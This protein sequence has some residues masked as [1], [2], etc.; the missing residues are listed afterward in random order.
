MVKLKVLSLIPGAGAAT[1]LFLAACQQSESPALSAPSDPEAPAAISS[2]SALQEFAG[3]GL[4]PSDEE[5]ARFLANSKP[6]PEVDLGKAPA[7]APLAK[8]AAVLATCRVNFDNTASLAVLQDQAYMGYAIHSYY[9]QP[10]NAS[11]TVISAP[12][13]G[14]GY[15]LIPENS[16]WCPGSAPLIGTRTANG[17]CIIQTEGKNWHRR[18]G[19]DANSDGVSF[20][21]HNSVL[22]RNFDLK[23]LY[24]HSGSVEVWGF[25]PAGS[26]LF[27]PALTAGKTWFFPAG[28]TLGQVRI[29]ESGRD[30]RFLVDNLDIAIH[31]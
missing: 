24:V 31:P 11:Y 3:P 17:S 7:P 16:S 27:W 20:N 14:G 8:T 12:I 22:Y 10:C 2:N 9:Q 19:N 25:T 15:R 13:T 4:K 28:T 1:L 23:A 29:Y 6:L 30:A 5:L 18:L 26:W 21:V